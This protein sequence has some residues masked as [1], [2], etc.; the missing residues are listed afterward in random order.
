LRGRSTDLK[1]PE[2]LLSTPSVKSFYRVGALKEKNLFGEDDIEARAYKALA[3]FFSYRVRTS[4]EVFDRLKKKGFSEE[5]IKRILT[6]WKKKGILDD[7]G[8]ARRWVAE[9][10]YKYG[11]FRLRAELASLGIPDNVIDSAISEI[12]REE[13]I[14]IVRELVDSLISNAASGFNLDSTDTSGSSTKITKAVRHRIL[15]K[16]LTRGFPKDIILE[17]LRD[18][19]S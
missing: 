16:L 2:E 12:S 13:W 7:E 9:R 19:A 17:V 18:V 3:R 11:P 14:E 8:F 6:S 15:T 5:E 10:K 1:K 4:R